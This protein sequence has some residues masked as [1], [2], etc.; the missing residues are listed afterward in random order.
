MLPVQAVEPADTPRWLLQKNVKSIFDF[1]P[2]FP[3]SNVLKHNDHTTL[4]RIWRRRMH[5]LTLR[6]KVRVGVRLS[7]CLSPWIVP[8]RKYNFQN[9]LGQEKGQFL[10]PADFLIRCHGFT[11]GFFLEQKLFMTLLY[12]NELWQRKLANSGSAPGPRNALLIL[13]Q[14]CTT[15]SPSPPLWKIKTHTTSPGWPLK[16]CEKLLR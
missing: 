14:A 15:A 16:H 10:P 1:W 13:R 3:P 4:R 12:G 6:E 7:L 11:S 2:R 8:D 9:I 5:P